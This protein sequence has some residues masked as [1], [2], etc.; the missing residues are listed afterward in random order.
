MKIES[1]KD[2]LNKILEDYEFTI[3]SVKTKKEFG[4][5]ILEILLKGKNITTDVLEQIHTKLFENLEDDLDDDYFLELSSVGA[6]YPLNS[7]DEVME[8]V[9]GYVYVETKDFKGV[10]LLLEVNNNELVIKYNQKGQFRK[11]KIEYDDVLN[12]RT[13]VKI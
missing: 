4:E 2:K 13:S 12:I 8:H 11:I 9:D 10:G 7:L 5:K 3:Y 6:E 1:I